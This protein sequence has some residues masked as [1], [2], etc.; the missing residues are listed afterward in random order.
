VQ[1]LVSP[2]TK[3]QLEHSRIRRNALPLLHGA[4]EA[5]RGH[6]FEALVDAD[7]ELGREHCALDRAEL[8]TFDL[9]RD[10]TQLACRINLRLDAPARITLERGSI[11]LAELVRRVAQRRKRDLHYIGFLLMILFLRPRRAKRQPP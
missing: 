2:E 6:H 7:Q 1:S 9:P 4:D 8:S 3:H 5:R 11:I 10:R